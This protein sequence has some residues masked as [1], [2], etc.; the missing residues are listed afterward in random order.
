MQNKT[1]GVGLLISLT[2][3][4]LTVIFEPTLHYAVA[5]S[6]YGLAGLGLLFFGIWGGIR[7][8]NKHYV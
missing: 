8:T 2:I 5:E 6:F 1:L 3:S 4:L 7:L